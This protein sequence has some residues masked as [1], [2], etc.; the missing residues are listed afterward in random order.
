[1]WADDMTNGQ[2]IVV[3]IA[4][5]GAIQAET[6]GIKGASCLDYIE[7][8][9]ELLDAATINSAFTH[10]YNETSNTIEHEV[11]REQHQR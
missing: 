9:E 1:M 5:D 8:L 6:R 10:E 3:R 2:Q 11:T 4:P 7:T